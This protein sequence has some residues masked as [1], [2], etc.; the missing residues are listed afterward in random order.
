MFHHWGVIRIL[1][2]DFSLAMN[3]GIS[4]SILLCIACCRVNC[5]YLTHI[6]MY[7]AGCTASIWC[8]RVAYGRLSFGW[9]G[10]NHRGKAG[11]LSTLCLPIHMGNSEGEDCCCEWNLSSTQSGR[12][13]VGVNLDVAKLRAFHIGHKNGISTCQDLMKSLTT[14]KVVLYGVALSRLIG[15]MNKLGVCMLGIRFNRSPKPSGLTRF[16]HWTS[17]DGERTAGNTGGI[18]HQKHSHVLT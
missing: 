12:I 8:G 9:F 18:K 17:L 2:S 4:Y 11:V 7:I 13:K 1:A 6:Y 10:G 5:I 3:G 15:V 14:M 16:G